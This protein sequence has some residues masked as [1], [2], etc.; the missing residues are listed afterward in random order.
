MPNLRLSFISAFNERVDPLMKGTVKPEGI[1][2]VPTYSHPSETFWRQLK[3]QEFEVGEMSLSSCLIARERG[4]DF[5]AL[6]VF[7]SRRLFHTEVSCHADSGIEKPEDL[8][9]KRFGVGEYQQTAA[10]WQRG[11]LEHDFGVSQYKVHWHMERTEELSHGGATGFTPPPGISFQRIPPEKSM[12]SMLV[13][14]ELDAAAINSPWR[15][16]PNVIGRSHRIPGA[17]G[18]WSKVNLLFADR[19]AEGKRFFSKWGFLPVNHAYTIR[20][21]IHRQ[22]PWVAF[23][24][25]AAFV[26]AKAEFNGKMLDSIPSGLFFGKEYLAR[27]Q[28]IFGKDPYPY[29]VKANR[30]MLE[31]L[32]DFSHEQGLIKQKP[33][34]EELFAES[35][36]DL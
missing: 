7:P 28:E 13:N 24:L 9:G 29:G 5:I 22:Y 11:I 20:G 14:R 12:A 10:L 21:D 16:A 15:N 18:D 33:R 17:D 32:V 30:K 2:L 8:V 1:E 6:P 36:R 19:I 26:K 34:V 31:T 25:F 35:T 3:F 4:F 27:T 23:N